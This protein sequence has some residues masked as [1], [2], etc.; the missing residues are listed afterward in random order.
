MYRTIC[1]NRFAGRT[2]M[3]QQNDFLSVLRIDRHIRD[4]RFIAISVISFVLRIDHYVKIVLLVERKWT[5]K[6]IFRKFLYMNDKAL[7]RNSDI[8]LFEATRGT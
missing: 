4:D 5:S 3:D 1:E 2:K 7:V 6:M 8:R